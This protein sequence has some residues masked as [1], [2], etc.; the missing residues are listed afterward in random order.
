[1]PSLS[2]A[3]QDLKSGGGHTFAVGSAGATPWQPYSRVYGLA[4]TVGDKGSV[5]EIYQVTVGSRGLG[6]P[7]GTKLVGF[8]RA[9]PAPTSTD[10]GTGTDILAGPTETFTPTVTSGNK[11]E[12]RIDLISPSGAAS[13]PKPAILD[14]IRTT[15]WRTAPDLDTMTIPIAYGPGVLMLGNTHWPSQSRSVQW[16]TDALVDMCRAGRLVMRDRAGQRWSVKLK[17]FFTRQS[18][19]HLQGATV[20]G[21]ITVA[22]LGT[23]V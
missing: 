13:P 20:R 6:D 9:D 14:S 22:I 2:G 21:E 5:K 18:S 8:V 19:H 4:T 12:G 16:T 17:H 15:Y 7:A 1:M 3:L 10:W 11:L 23:A